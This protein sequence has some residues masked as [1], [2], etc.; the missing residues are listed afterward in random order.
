MLVGGQTSF[1]IQHSPTSKPTMP[2]T[3][4]RSNT[5]TNTNTN[6]NTKKHRITFSTPLTPAP[7]KTNDYEVDADG[8]VIMTDAF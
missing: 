4:K 7:R 5:T 6:T 1:I 2:T 8:D 3:Q